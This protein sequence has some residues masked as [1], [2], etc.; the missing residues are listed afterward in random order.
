[1]NAAINAVQ[2]LADAF[3]HASYVGFSDITYSDRDW[4][5]FQIWKTEVRD[6]LTREE[7]R[8]A[9]EPN[10][11]RITKQRKHTSLDISVEAMFVQTWSSTALGFGGIGGQAITDAYTI[12]LR[13]EVTGEHCVYFGS[14]FA[15]RIDHPNDNFYNDMQSRQMAHKAH[16]KGLSAKEWY[17]RTN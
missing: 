13:S 17:E 6:K 7:Q 9:V 4:E 5:K 12:I 8:T 1:M 16:P 14:R 3:G 15:Y 10:S 11:C 2:N